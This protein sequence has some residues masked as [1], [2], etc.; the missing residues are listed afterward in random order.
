MT[1]IKASAAL[2]ITIAVVAAVFKG[3]FYIY[4]KLDS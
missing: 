3:A 4:D 1:W 2:L